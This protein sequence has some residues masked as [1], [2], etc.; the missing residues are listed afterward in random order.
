MKRIL[1]N[2]EDKDYCPCQKYLKD[3]VDIYRGM[4]EQFCT[5]EKRE[6]NKNICYELE[7]FPFYYSYITN[8]VEIKKRIPDIQS[9]ERDEF[10][11]VG[12]F[13]RFGNKNN[14]KITSNFDKE[15]ENE[16]F[17]VIQKDSNIKDIHS[18]YNI[19]YEPI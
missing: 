19:G 15:I 3:C 4:K 10:T 17:N 7:Q 16:L 2:T 13:F 5:S 11:P 8:D 12:K 14:T 18:K 1:K 9:G 6:N